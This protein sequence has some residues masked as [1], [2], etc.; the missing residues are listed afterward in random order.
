MNLV[1][2]GFVEADDQIVRVCQLLKFPPVFSDEDGSSSG[3]FFS[4]ASDPDLD[5][6]HLPD[7]PGRFHLEA[8][9]LL[10]S[11]EGFAQ[12]GGDRD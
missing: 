1:M 10:L 9:A 5:H 12:G 3:A 11:N 8:H 6:L 4:F 7:A 2:D